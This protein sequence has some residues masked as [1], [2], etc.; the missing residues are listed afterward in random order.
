LEHRRPNRL[1]GLDPPTG[2]TAIATKRLELLHETVPNT[3]L[4]A[5]VDNPPSTFYAQRLGAV[6][7][8]VGSLGLVLVPRCEN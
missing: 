1:L 6:K 8:A 4:V 7:D 3:A 5:A 2:T